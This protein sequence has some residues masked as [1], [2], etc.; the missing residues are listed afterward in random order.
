MIAAVNRGEP[1]IVE[2]ILEAK[3]NLNLKDEKERTALQVAKEKG[4]AKIVEILKSA[5]AIE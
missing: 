4:N 2:L 3:P 5:G 1:E